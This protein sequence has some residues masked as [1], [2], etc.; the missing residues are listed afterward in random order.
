MRTQALARSFLVDP[1]LLVR[2]ASETLTSDPE[3]GEPRKKTIAELQQQKLAEQAKKIEMERIRELGGTALNATAG[4][5]RGASPDGYAAEAASPRS[6]PMVQPGKARFEGVNDAL[7]LETIMRI[8][9]ETSGPS[10]KMN[11]L[12]LSQTN[13]SY[14]SGQDTKVITT[15]RRKWETMTREGGALSGRMTEEM[16]TEHVNNLEKLEAL[17]DHIRHINE[18][19]DK[20]KDERRKRLQS[21]HIFERLDEVREKRILTRHEKRQKEWEDFRARMV[22]KL[23]KV[24]K[25]KSIPIFIPTPIPISMTRPISHT[26]MHALSGR[27][28]GKVNKH[29]FKG[30]VNKHKCV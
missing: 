21:L 17:Q 8:K 2:Q 3:P 16:M 25:H 28:K 19:R 11:P 10:S 14:L 15:E 27:F 26:C 18:T 23:G 9:G 7:T 5:F 29:K 30:K 4:S 6:V 13:A 1:S 22:K 20:E 24:Y 12:A